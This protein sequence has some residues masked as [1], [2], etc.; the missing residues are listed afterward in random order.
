MFEFL[1]DKVLES[2]GRIS[3]GEWCNQIY[4]IGYSL[5]MDWRRSSMELLRLVG[6]LMV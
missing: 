1:L 6:I 4:I 2:Q 5:G 3:V